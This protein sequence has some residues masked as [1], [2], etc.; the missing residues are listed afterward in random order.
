VVFDFDGL[1]IDSETEVAACVVDALA[2]RGLTFV[3]EDVAHL[4]GS[5]DVDEEWD[6]VLARLGL[7]LAELRPS[8]DAVL[9]PRV[10]ALPLLPG[11]VE[12]LDA[13]ASSRWATAIATGTERGRLDAHLARLGLEGRFDVIVTRG[14]VERGKPAPDIYLAAAARLQA[15]ADEC[16]ALEDSVPGCAAALA[17]GMRVVVC[18]SPVTARCAFPASVRRV[19]SL[20][21]VARSVPSLFATPVDL[22]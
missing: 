15:R 1:M 3:V 12:V 5:T 14:E 8:V 6:R 9:R 16:L 10:D 2:A 20:A 19:A 13:A 11:V 21:E 18:P 22:R 17:A 7:T 4:F